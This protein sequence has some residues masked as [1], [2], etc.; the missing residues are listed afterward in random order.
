MS[1]KNF[2]TLFV[3]AFPPERC[4]LVAWLTLFP[5]AGLEPRFPPEPPG[6]F[7]GAAA[8]REGALLYEL[9]GEPLADT[10]VA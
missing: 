3:Q 2:R 10:E 1:R 9:S 8:L 7:R 6:P 4:P 5:P